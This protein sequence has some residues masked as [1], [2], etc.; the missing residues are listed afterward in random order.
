MVDPVIERLKQRLL[1]IMKEQDLRAAP[2]ARAALL[3]E[4]AVRDILRGRSENPG[5]AT[6]AKLARVLNRRTSELVDPDITEKITGTVT[7][8]GAISDN[9]SP[10]AVVMQA[11]SPINELCQSQGF[12][13]YQFQTDRLEPYAYRGDLVI[14]AQDK[15]AEPHDFGRPHLISR[16]GRKCLGLPIIWGRGENLEVLAINGRGRETILEVD[17]FFSRTLGV[18]PMSGLQSPIRPQSR[19]DSQG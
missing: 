3:N 12:D 11:G 10:K 15:T 14:V 8:D 4:S 9:E 18:F 13:L 7:D 5:I 6:I 1:N 19:L 2:L 16:N 17:V